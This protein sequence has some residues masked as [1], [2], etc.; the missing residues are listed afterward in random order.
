M[1]VIIK[2]TGKVK[3]L[4]MTGRDGRDYT[5]DFIGNHGGFVNGD[6]VEVD[7]EFDVYMCSQDTYDWWEEVISD[8]ERLEERIEEL[9]EKYGRDEVQRALDDL[10]NM[11]DVDLEGYARVVNNQ[12]DE[13]FGKG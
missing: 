4:C 10:G 13:V 1:D 7:K 9:E 12:L 5:T 8:N 11:S 3:E 2:E 6:F